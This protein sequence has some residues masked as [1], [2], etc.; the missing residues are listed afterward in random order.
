MVD[1]K[2]KR[3]DTTPGKSMDRL[4]FVLSETFTE[5][6]G[7]IFWKNHKKTNLIGKEAGHLTKSGYYFVKVGGVS[8]PVHRVVWVLHNGDL[9]NGVEIDHIDRNKSNNIITNLRAVDKSTNLHNIVEP[10][11]GKM[12]KERNIYERENG[13]FRVIVTVNRTRHNIGEFDTLA[14]AVEQRDEFKKR[15]LT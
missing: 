6:D 15:I 7:K 12:L 8:V 1:T 9:C 2:S 5:K 14:K 3:K 10:N 4:V 13:V 11:K